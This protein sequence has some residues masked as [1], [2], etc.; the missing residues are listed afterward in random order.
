MKQHDKNIKCIYFKNRLKLPAKAPTI[1]AT[2]KYGNSLHIF[3]HLFTNTETLFLQAFPISR[4][5]QNNE[6]RAKH[7]TCFYSNGN[8]QWRMFGI[9]T[10]PKAKL[11]GVI[12]RLI[13]VVVPVRLIDKAT[14]DFEIAE[15][16]LET[17][18]PG[19]AATKIIP[20]ATAVL[21]FKIRTSRYVSAGNRK[22]C[23][24]TPTIADFGC[25]ITSLKCFGFIPNAT[26][27]MMNAMATFIMFTVPGL[28]FNRTLSNCSMF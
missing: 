27:N 25:I 13:T 12:S 26:P 11:S 22:Y 5:Y 3:F 20:I 24:I 23:E 17:F 7:F 10:A 28:K 19:H 14:F 4:E 1:K 8:K 21:G 15:I 9:E 16:R 18:P 6:N 2:K